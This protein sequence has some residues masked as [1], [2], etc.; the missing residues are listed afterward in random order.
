MKILS[1]EDELTL[2]KNLVWIFSDRR[3]GTTWF[4]K[5]LL[6]FQ[7]KS[8]DEPLIGLHLGRSFQIKNGFARTLD[9]Q[10]NRSD[11]FLSKEYEKTWKFFL[12]K[13][14][15]NRIHSQFND[16]SNIIVIK[17]PTGSMGADI[18]ADCM[19]NSKIIILLRDGRDV[20]DSKID[21]DSAG[22][23]ELELKKGFREG[24]TE[25]KR[26]DHIKRH[27][28]FWK[29]LMEILL[30]T[31]ENHPNDLRYMLR[32]ENLLQN[33][34]TELK[35]VY[36]FLGINI[37]ESKLQKIIDK[38]SFENIPEDKKGRG[39]FRRYASPGKWKEHF[40]EE[41]KKVMNEIM[42]DVL[43]KLEY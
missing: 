5:E 19:P 43:K 40:H 3:S 10:K 36:H 12:R 14:I 25:K 31:Y 1:P 7:T 9:V 15:L 8:L 20:V 23:W 33:T 6:S 27:S 39:E 2:E 32:Y 28:K 34:L 18:L 37:D 41:E 38:Y 13:L 42:K 16:I 35:K 26:L 21:E 29:S 22:G 11:Y 24:I 4:A 17:E 30:K